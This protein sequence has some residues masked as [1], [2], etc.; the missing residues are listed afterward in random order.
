M[1][2]IL[3][4]ILPIV[5]LISI[6]I[7]IYYIY[8]KDIKISNDALIG[9]NLYKFKITKD[10]EQILAIKEEDKYLYTLISVINDKDL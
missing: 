5:S 4:I 9:N 6:S 1:N 7:V 10:Y 8:N 3:K 2:K